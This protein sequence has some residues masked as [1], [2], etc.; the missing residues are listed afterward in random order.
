M[1]S[2]LWRLL[3]LSIWVIAL[4]LMLL[5]SPAFAAA[6][7]WDG[8]WD[9][10]WRGGGA[11]LYLTQDGDRVTGTYPLYGGKIEGVT[12]G[13]ELK[14]RWTDTNGSGEFVAIRSS[15]DNS[16]TARLGNGEWWTGIRTSKDNQFLGQPIDQSSPASTL[17]YFMMIMNAI[18]HGTMELKS[19]AT[20]LIDWTSDTALGI[21]RLDYTDLLFDVLNELTFRTWNLKQTPEGQNY[22]VTLT[23]AGTGINFTLGFVKRG[24]AWLITTQPTTVLASTLKTLQAAQANLDNR[25]TTGFDSPRSSLKTLMTGFD[26][27]DP[28]SIDRVIRALDLSNMSDLAKKYESRRIAGYLK[29]AISRIGTPIWQEIPN[30]PKDK[31]PYVLFDHPVGSITL[32]PR[33]TD[34]GTIW[35]FTP[36]TLNSIRAL[37]AAIDNMPLAAHQ[38]SNE[39]QN[40]AYFKLR[41][42]FNKQHVLWTRGFGPLQLWQWL[43]M[44]LTICLAYVLGRLFSRWIGVALLKIFQKNLKDHPFYQTSLIWSLRLLFL[45]VAIRLVDEPLGLP[46]RVEVFVLTLGFSAIVISI[47][48]ILLIVVNLVSTQISRA[49]AVA[50]NNITL[51]SLSAGVIRVVIVIGGILA[52]ADLLEVPYQGVLAGLGVGGLAVA[53]AAQSTLQNFISGITIYFD[54]PIAIGDYCRFGTREGTVEFIGMR[55]TRIRTLDRTLLTVPN[56]EFSNLQIENYALRDRMF[57]NTTIQVRYETTP[58]QLRF[59]LAEIRK[60]LIAHPKIAPDP[61][62]VRFSGFG[63]HSLDITI[64]AYVMTNVRA[65]FLAIQ[66]DLFL[67]VMSL[68]TDSGAQFAFPSMVQYQ[69]KDTLADPEKIK[70]AEAAV[71]KWR[72]ESNLPFPDFSWQEKSEL[73]ETLDYP[74]TGSAVAHEYDPNYHLGQSKSAKDRVA[75]KEPT[76]P[77]DPQA[78]LPQDPAQPKNKLT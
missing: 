63:S 30:D 36:E 62:R 42:F 52:L 44:L 68:V 12:S 5:Q 35:Q 26:V 56:S 73:S 16:F 39:E 40:S 61:L 45:G 8:Q 78:E 21:S 58:D 47:T 55:S 37:Y 6:A 11:R 14:G 70:A 67:R 15:D 50:G 1:N 24:Q 75:A 31:H 71:A 4:L 38:F 57:L 9:T 53:L 65:E 51:V 2:L 25:R 41:D 33:E 10:R 20:H 59:L 19:E 66:E 77:T 54:K 60:L 7:N 74:P 76:L 23:Q 48:M 3:S 17:Y 69:A 13:R 27:T 34:A 72:E 32:A 43:G 29:R 49:Q 18:G 28:S 64:F 22:E 46:D